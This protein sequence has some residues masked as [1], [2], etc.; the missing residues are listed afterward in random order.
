MHTIKFFSGRASRYLAEKI[1]DSFGSELGNSTVLE[2]S[3]GEF[4]PAFDERI[5]A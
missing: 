2:V 3:D 5:Y 4:H 1:A